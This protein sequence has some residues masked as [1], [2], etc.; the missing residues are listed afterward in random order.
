[1]LVADSLAIFRS[2]VRK[3]LEGEGGWEVIEAASLSELAWCEDAWPDIA[4]IDSDLP[5]A[6]AIAAVGWLNERCDADTIVWSLEPTGDDVLAAICAGASGYLHKEIPPA[7][8]LRALN[9][10]AR[11][12]AQLSRP[13]VTLM[14]AALHEN[15]EREQAGE[16]LA[17]L[18]AREREVLELLAQGLRTRVVAAQ[19]AISEFTVRRHV[20]NILRK[21][22]LHS[23]DAAQELYRRAVGAPVV[24]AEVVSSA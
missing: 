23:R 21:L 11:N 18:S 22:E 4:L 9:G 16:L 2:G 8:L 10:V 5:P 6:G 24:G 12:E 19:L 7:G 13:L 1:V 17:M 15:V 14:V 3:L 20:Q